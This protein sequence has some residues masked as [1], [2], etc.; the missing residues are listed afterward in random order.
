MS[1]VIYDPIMQCIYCGDASSEL[2]DE[3]IIPYS[4]GGVLVLPKSS[5]RKCAHITHKFEGVC[6]RQIFGKF[7]A[8]HNLPTRRP[9]ERSKFLQV[10]TILP[11]GM[12]KKI[13]IPVSEHPTELFVFKFHRAYALEGLPP[14]VDTPHWVP[15]AICDNEELNAFQEKYKWDG[16]IQF[17]ASVNEYAK[18]LAKIGHSYAVANIGLGLFKPI[19]LDLIMGRTT[20]IAYAVG[21]D[22]DIE[23]AVLGGKHILQMGV[24]V[25]PVRSRFFVV[26]NIRLFSSCGMPSYHVVVGQ[27]ETPENASTIADKIDAPAWVKAMG[28]ALQP[29]NFLR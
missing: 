6:A 18:M 16:I 19:A 21:G 5:C 12:T 27:I 7:R 23:P 28:N 13:E 22:F 17:K 25:D 2:S 3:H 15:V 20:N 10:G 26:V 24:Q 1:E 14:N 8:K 11:D 4:L 9:K 29:Q